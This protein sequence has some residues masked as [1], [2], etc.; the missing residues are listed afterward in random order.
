MI[1]FNAKFRDWLTDIAASLHAST[2]CCWMIGSWSTGN[3]HLLS[4]VS[5]GG[6]GNQCPKEQLTVH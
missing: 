2:L 1:G 3:V 5:G 6:V 4:P